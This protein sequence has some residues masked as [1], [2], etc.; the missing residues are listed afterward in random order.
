MANL[1]DETQGPINNEGRDVHVID[2]QIPVTITFKS[3]LFEIALWITIP[4]L[5]LLYVCF[6]GN[7]L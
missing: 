7:Q 2:R 4:L 3:T 5:V 1:L 6:M